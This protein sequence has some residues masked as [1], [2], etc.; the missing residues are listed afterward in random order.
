MM[1][2]HNLGHKQITLVRPLNCARTDFIEE[3]Y[4][5]QKK[6]RNA[7]G[8]KLTSGIGLNSEGMYNLDVFR[9]I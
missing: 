8:S 4:R 9:C 5:T 2:K 6:A 7:G 3:I 1:E